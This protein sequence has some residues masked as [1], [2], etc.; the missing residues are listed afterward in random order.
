M[1][2]MM[3]IDKTGQAMLLISTQTGGRRAC[4]RRVYYSV[5]HFIFIIGLCTYKKRLYVPA[6]F[7]YDDKY[8]KNT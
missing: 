1:Y 7:V 2:M 3:Y 8:R 4:Y 6:K 5:F